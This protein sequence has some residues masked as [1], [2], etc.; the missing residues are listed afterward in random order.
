MWI[1]LPAEE[2]TRQTRQNQ[3]GSNRVWTGKTGIKAACI[4]NVGLRLARED[5]QTLFEQLL[6][7]PRALTMAQ[8]SDLDC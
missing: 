7:K 5:G 2:A 1:A 4:T 8:S 6:R 3:S